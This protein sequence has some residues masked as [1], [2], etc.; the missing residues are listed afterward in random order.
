MVKNTSTFADIPLTPLTGQMDLRSPSGTVPMGDFRLV[1]NA[2]MNEL[3]KRCRRPGFRKYGF[4]SERGFNNQDLHDQLLVS[5]GAY[6]NDPVISIDPPSGSYVLAGTYIVL[7]TDVPGSSIYY[8]TNGTTPTTASALYTAPFELPVG[9]ETIKAIGVDE[10]CTSIVFEF[11][12]NYSDEIADFL[13]FHLLCNTD[14]KSGVFFEFEPNGDSRDYIWDLSFSFDQDIVAKRLEIYETTPSGSWI[15]GQA[16]ATNN[17]VYPPELSGAP[18]SIYP[19]VIIE[20]EDQLNSEYQTIAVPSVTAGPHHWK[21]YGQPFVPNVGYFK[22]VWTVVIDGVES[23]IYKLITNE[24]DCGYYDDGCCYYDDG[25]CIG[26][27]QDFDFRYLCETGDFAGGFGDF[28]ANGTANDFQ[29]ALDFT[30]SEP[31]EILGI[32]IYSSNEIGEPVGDRWSSSEFVYPYGPDQ[33]GVAYP[34]V[35]FELM[36]KVTDVY[37]DSLGTFTAGYHE[38]R[39]WGQPSHPPRNTFALF[40]RLGNGV[41][42]RKIASGTCV[43]S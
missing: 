15:T 41:V 38:W 8:T 16:W 19:L 21:L 4:S 13:E 37:V 40:I 7:T 28:N 26:N 43:E 27:A 2:S 34:A 25:E 23:K 29:F 18:F 9:V 10:T 36:T 30:L 32:D 6:C 20:A 39:I 24:C 42:I 31:T 5:D 17:P 11:T 35:I 3:R 14:D 1:L 12:Y 22:L 33:P